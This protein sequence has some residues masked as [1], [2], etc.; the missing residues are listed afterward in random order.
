MHFEYSPYVLPLIAAALVSVFVAVYA[1]MRRSA[2]GAFVVF[3]LAVAI[4]EWTVGYSLEIAGADLETKYFWAVIQYIGI[5]FV[6]YG[7]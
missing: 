1:W 3:L 6:P 4:F 2:N 5:A 7:C